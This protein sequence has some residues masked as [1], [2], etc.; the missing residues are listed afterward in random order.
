MKQCRKVSESYSKVPTQF[1]PR[2]LNDTAGGSAIHR[3]I[4]EEIGRR[5]VLN[6][7]EE[8]ERETCLLFSAEEW[9]RT[10]CA[11]PLSYPRFTHPFL[12]P[13]FYPFRCPP[14]LRA[15]I[16]LSIPIARCPVCGQQKLPHNF[17]CQSCWLSLPREI[18]RAVR[19]RKTH[20]HSLAPGNV[21]RAP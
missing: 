17:V 1:L 9:R 20:R 12:P 10:L 15:T 16:L 5:K 8:A 3:A 2:L 7:P 14:V 21:G 11:N 4:L 13:A 19:H 18:A 6:P